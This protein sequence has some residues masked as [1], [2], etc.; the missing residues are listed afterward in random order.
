MVDCGDSGCRTALHVLAIDRITRERIQDQKICLDRP[1]WRW[2]IALNWPEGG[3]ITFGASG[4]TQT[5]RAAPVV[6]DQQQ[7]PP[8][9]RM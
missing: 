7:L 5:L 8:A 3:A 4:F 9:E 1:Y 2:R 6:L